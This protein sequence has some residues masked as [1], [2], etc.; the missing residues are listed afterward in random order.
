MRLATTMRGKHLDMTRLM[1]KNEN[2][3]AL[4]NANMNARGDIINRNGTVK[5]SREN[6]ARD[7]HKTNP[8]A[9]KQVSL[10]NIKDEA[11]SSPAEALARHNQQVA[12]A[13]KQKRK[14]VDND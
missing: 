5:I 9:V 8:K 1:A 3:I 6:M 10:R 12:A 11:V 13:Q 4:G 7:Y 14:I 2:K